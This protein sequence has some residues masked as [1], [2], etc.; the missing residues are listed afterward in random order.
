MRVSAEEL[1]GDNDGCSGTAK[2]IELSNVG[3]STEIQFPSNGQDHYDN[4]MDCE[5]LLT[6]STNILFLII[7]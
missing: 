2:A 4:N 3:D 5:W 1:T 6:V 7:K